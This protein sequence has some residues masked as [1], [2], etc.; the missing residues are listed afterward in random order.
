M[1]IIDSGLEHCK[2]SIPVN[3]E[4]VDI[5]WTKEKDK[6]N[7]TLSLPEGYN[8]KVITTEKEVNVSLK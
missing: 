7:V 6:F 1:R 3:E 4:S 2:G 8:Y 5:E